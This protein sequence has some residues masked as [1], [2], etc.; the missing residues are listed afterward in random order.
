MDILV[1]GTEKYTQDIPKLQFNI[2]VNAQLEL[3]QSTDNLAG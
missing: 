1:K 3:K 2:L